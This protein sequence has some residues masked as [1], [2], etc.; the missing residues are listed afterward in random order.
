M[1]RRR[2]V[3]RIQ[4]RVQGVS[5]RESARAEALRLGLTG[6]VRNLSDGSVEALAEGPPEALEA[7]VTWCHRGPSLARVTDVARTEAPAQGQFTT[8]LVERSS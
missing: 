8:F 2:A 7:F 1:D 3:L 5:F 4:G 6:W